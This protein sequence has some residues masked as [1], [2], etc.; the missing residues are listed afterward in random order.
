MSMTGFWAATGGA[1]GGEVLESSPVKTAAAS[2]NSEERAKNKRIS[3]SKDCSECIAGRTASVPDWKFSD[4]AGDAMMMLIIN[5]RA[6]RRPA[7]NTPYSSVAQW[8]SIRLLT[9]G[10]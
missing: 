10:L 4:G 5:R 7:H 6:L 2:K 1:E 3:T 9:E 8:Q